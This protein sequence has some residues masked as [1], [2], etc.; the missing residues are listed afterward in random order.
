MLT[1]V[2]LP[3]RRFLS[4]VVGRLARG[5]EAV[6]IKLNRAVRG[7][8]TDPERNFP[9][10]TRITSAQPRK[11]ERG[12]KSE[13]TKSSRSPRPSEIPRARIDP[14]GDEVSRPSREQ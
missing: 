6:L 12:R 5:E 2:E 3:K 14:D 8:S 1:S 9:E 10:R 11:D 7:E 13:P 4:E